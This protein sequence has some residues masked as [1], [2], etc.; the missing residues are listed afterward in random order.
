MNGVNLADLEKTGIE[1]EVEPNAYSGGEEEENERERLKNY[2]SE[3]I[4]QHVNPVCMQAPDSS[5][6]IDY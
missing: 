1:L 3:E 2:K 5:V 6:S 4:W